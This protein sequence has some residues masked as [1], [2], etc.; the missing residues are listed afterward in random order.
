[1]ITFRDISIIIP[2]GPGENALEAL[3]GDLRPIEKEAELIVVQGSS[4]AQQLNEGA[5]NATRDFLWF[6]HADSRLSSKTLAA[7]LG[8]LGENPH[9]L[10]YFHLR[11][12]PDG[13]PLMCINEIG[14]WIRS[15]LMGLPFGDQGFAVAKE[16]FETMG[17]FP[18]NVPYGEDH[19]FVWRAMQKRVP[20]RCTG[21]SLYTSAR[22][23]AE[24][25]WARLTWDYARRWTRQ[26]WPEWKKLYEKTSDVRQVS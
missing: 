22:R 21:A 5:R 13:P 1:M 23:Y 2:V 15:R 20:L 16:V 12:L 10:H 8:S 14:C 11:F 4:R 19:L 26:A 6:L 3:L 25:G 9:A 17:G 18:E 24:T 7:L